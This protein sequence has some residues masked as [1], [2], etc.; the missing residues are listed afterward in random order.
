M[1][2]AQG[3][4]TDLNQI[5]LT[6]VRAIALIGLLILAPRSLEEIKQNFVKLKIMDNEN[7]D[8]ILRIDMNTIKAM[9]CEIS[10]LSA[11]TGHKYV[12]TKHPFSLKL[13]LEDARIFKRVYNKI[14]PDA[15][16]SLLLEYDNLF[17]RIS[18][19]IYDK[20]IKE[21][22]CGISVLKYFDINNIRELISDCNNEHTLNLTYKN[23]TTGE[24]SSKNVIAQKLVFKNDKIYLYC[25]DL[26]KKKPVILNLARIKEILSRKNT[27][28]LTEPKTVNVKFILKDFCTET[29]LDE[30]VVLEEV[31]DYIIVEGHYFNEFI[32]TQRILSFGAR[33]TVLEPEAFKNSII[34]KLKKMREIYADE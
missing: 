31:N 6:G 29:L 5:S 26:A 28:N 34:A 25:Y 12:L 23:P 1:L 2:S 27:E 19:K 18:E 33:C 4:K 7:S 3:K 22:F 11:K 17:K 32:A 13:T 14:K 8:D 10:R 15:D 21:A 20:D 24:G 30:E 9:G 16:I